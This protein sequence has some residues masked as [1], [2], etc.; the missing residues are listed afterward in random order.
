MVSNAAD[1]RKQKKC[2]RS[3]LTNSSR[4]PNEHYCLEGSRASPLCFFG[5]SN[6]YV[7]LIRTIAG[8]IIIIIIIIMLN[9]IM[10]YYSTC[11]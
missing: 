2:E 5:K 6:M 4:Y 9:N 11:I 7:R 10:N 1:I 8:I 3:F